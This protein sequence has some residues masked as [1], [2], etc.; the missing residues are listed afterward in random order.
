MQKKCLFL[1]FLSLFFSTFALDMQKG[2][3]I[4]FL[5]DVGG[6]VVVQY[7]AQRQ[8]VW[9]ETEDGFYVGPMPAAKCV[10]CNQQHSYQR[11]AHGAT[12]RVVEVPEPPAQPHVAPAKRPKRQRDEHIIDLHLD[13]LPTS[14]SGMTSVEKHQYQLRFFRL[15][16]QQHLRYRGRRVVVVHGKGD[17]VLKRE[18]RQILKRDFGAAVEVHDA[19]FSRYEEGAT[20][21]I[22]K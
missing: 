19:D 12:P 1:W 13:A 9:V 18:V 8:L 5:D 7:D 22:I 11:M 15:E 3:T 6:G 2:D 21:V 4:R 10:V 14:G 20:L 17:G 16:M